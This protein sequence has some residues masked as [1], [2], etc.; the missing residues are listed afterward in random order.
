MKVFYLPIFFLHLILLHSLF[1]IAT[2]LV[3][4]IEVRY[5]ELRWWGNWQNCVCFVF[6]FAKSSDLKKQM[7]TLKNWMIRIWSQ[8]NERFCSSIVSTWTLAA[9]SSYDNGCKCFLSSFCL[10]IKK[11][12]V[13]LYRNI[14]VQA[15][16]AKYPSFFFSSQMWY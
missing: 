10:Q 4:G 3:F 6:I 13:Y 2:A 11:H 14:L 16:F 9:Q 5:L 15:I 7:R 8:W 1:S 12:R